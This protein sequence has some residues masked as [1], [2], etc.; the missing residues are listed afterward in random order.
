AECQ[1]NWL[2]SGSLKQQVDYWVS[3]L[4]GAAKL[5]LPADHPR[6]T[7][8]TYRGAHLNFTLSSDLTTKLRDLSQAEGVTLFMTLLAAFKVLLFATRV[9]ATL[10][11]AYQSP[12]AIQ[13][14]LKS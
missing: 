1:R 13:L 3:Q 8:R 10:L 14:K 5:S 4:A 12:V 2:K 6:P 11:S 9:N 7:V